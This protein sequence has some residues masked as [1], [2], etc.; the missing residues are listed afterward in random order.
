MR[1]TL[2]IVLAAAML[3]LGCA[4]TSAGSDATSAGTTSPEV[5]AEPSATAQAATPEPEQPAPS[6]EP[7]VIPLTLHLAV[8]AGAPTSALSSQRTLEELRTIAEDMQQIWAQADVILAPI[9]V[10]QVEVPTEVLQ[11]VLLGNTDQFFAQVNAT[12]RPQSSQAINGFYV[13]SAFGANGFTPQGSNLFFVVDS[14]S[15]PDER[16]SSHEVG[17]ILGLHHDLDDPS[18]LMFSGTS[19]S[20]LTELEQTVARYTAVGLFPQDAAA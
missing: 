19:G 9:N 8:E 20:Q 13:R 11:G 1:L 7:V 10:H 15:V 17:H 5:Q 14:P 4:T 12:F 3:L 2:G 6:R 16:V 18:R